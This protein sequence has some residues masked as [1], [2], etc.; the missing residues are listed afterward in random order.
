MATIGARLVSSH[1]SLFQLK[2]Q[3]DTEDL[4]KVP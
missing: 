3:N 1:P 2:F 4:S